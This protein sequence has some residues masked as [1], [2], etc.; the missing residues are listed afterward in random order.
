MTSP[1]VSIAGKSIFSLFALLV[2]LVDPASAADRPNVVLI[3]VDDLN[4][5]CGCLGGHPQASTPHL[6]RLADRGMLFANAHCQGT[7]CNPSR[8]SLLWGWSWILYTSDAAD[9]R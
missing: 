6:D 9:E 7:M 8:I 5:W 2:L 3:S 1:L 4:D